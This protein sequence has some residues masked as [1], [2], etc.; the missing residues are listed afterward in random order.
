LDLRTGL[1]H[2]LLDS[3][4]Y[5]QPV[6]RIGGHEPENHP[7]LHHEPKYNIE[8]AWFLWEQDEIGDAIQPNIPT[9][10]AI[11]DN[12]SAFIPSMGRTMC[13]R[14]ATAASGMPMPLSFRCA[15]DR[16]RVISGRL[17]RRD[18]VFRTGIACH[19]GA[20]AVEIHAYIC[21]AGNPAQDA[22]GRFS[23]AAAGHSRDQKHGGSTWFVR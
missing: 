8:R 18:E 17:D 16:L 19:R 2:T 5:Q 20:T 10:K 22:C 3:P 12:V 9:S 11:R 7:D 4:F 23:A 6:R 14:S 21:G 13:A 15:A 1:L